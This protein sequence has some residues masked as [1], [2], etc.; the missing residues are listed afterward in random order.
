M[1]P[2]LSIRR[3]FVDRQHDLDPPLSNARVRGELVDLTADSDYD[4]EAPTTPR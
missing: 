2:Q 3:F 1:S 4:E